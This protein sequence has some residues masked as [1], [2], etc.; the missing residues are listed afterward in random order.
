M[1]ATKW[2]TLTGFIQYLGKSGKCTVDETES[3]SIYCSVPNK[4]YENFNLYHHWYITEGWYIT[5]I[6][7]DPETIARQEASQKA[8]KLKKDDEERNA[9]FILKQ[10]AL[11]KK[12]KEGMPGLDEHRAEFTDLVRTSEDQKIKLGL[13]LSSSQSLLATQSSNLGNSSKVFKPPKMSGDDIKSEKKSSSTKRK[14]S[15]NLSQIMQEEIAEKKNAKKS[16]EASWLMTGIHVKVITKSLGDKYYKQKGY[17]KSLVDDYTAVVVITSSGS[18]VK[19]DQSHL[20]TVIPAIGRHV[21]VLSGKHRGKE[22]VLLE[23]NVK[24]FS[25]N[26]ELTQNGNQVTLFYEQFS[27]KYDSSK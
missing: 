16:E 27:K 20:E 2:V 24:D 22:G 17:I 25:A 14:S 5:W 21:M 8:E 4:K 11:D 19:L 3:K 10:V 18:K 9:D 6:D 23:L 1:N 7:R 12:R 26:I 13:N 15:S